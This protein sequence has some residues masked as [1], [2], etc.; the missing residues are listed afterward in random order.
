LEEIDDFLDGDISHRDAVDCVIL[1]GSYATGKATERSDVDLCYIGAFD[2]VSREKG[3]M[4]HGREYQLMIAPW[5]WY[6]NVPISFEIT[7]RVA[8]I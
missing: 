1:C 8:S 4:H 7:R 5:S 6:K 3:M 2:D